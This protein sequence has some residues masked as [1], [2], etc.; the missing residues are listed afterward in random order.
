MFECHVGGA[1]SRG[2]SVS[3]EYES[4]D[5][6]RSDFSGGIREVAG[7]G[8]GGALGP[9]GGMAVGMLFV[10]C[11][12]WVNSSEEGAGLRRDGGDGRDGWGSCGG[13]N[14]GDPCSS[15]LRRDLSCPGYS[16]AIALPC[17]LSSS[18]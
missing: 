3:A 10:L 9:K 7:G 16:G 4:T 14:V 2:A 1:D 12:G 17:G 13:V 5:D 18:F 11:F 6:L 8:D 15:R